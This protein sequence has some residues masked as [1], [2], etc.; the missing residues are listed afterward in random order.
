MRSSSAGQLPLAPTT[1][2]RSAGPASP[3]V[4]LSVAAPF[5]PGTDAASTPAAGTAGYPAPASAPYQ[6]VHDTSPPPGAAAPGAAAHG[7]HLAPTPPSTTTT[8]RAPH[9]TT[10]TARAPHTTTT[11][12]ARAGV[13]LAPTPHVTT[14]TFTTTPAPPG[15][16]RDWGA[17]PSTSG[18]TTV[19]NTVP[20]SLDTFD[21]ITV[22]RFLCH[23]SQW[24]KELLDRG[25]YAPPLSGLLTP[26]FLGYSTK[27]LHSTLG[28]LWPAYHDLADASSG[29][30][31]SAMRTALWQY[32][33]DDCHT[34]HEDPDT[35]WATLS[36]TVLWPRQPSS[37]KGALFDFQMAFEELLQS[38][39]TVAHA[40]TSTLK[41]QKRTVNALV[42]KLSP[43]SWRHAVHQT[44]EKSDKYTI[45]SFFALL[46]SASTEI[47]FHAFASTA[48]V[49][50]E[51]PPTPPT[52]TPHP[53]TSATPEPPFSPY[54]T[55]TPSRPCRFCSGRHMDNACPTRYN[56]N[57]STSAAPGT[58]APTAT[59]TSTSTSATT[60]APPP[61][62][63]RF[64][65]AAHWHSDCP[66]NPAGRTPSTSTSRH[67]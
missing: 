17:L 57:F 21:H 47:Q 7:V 51:P 58:T 33:N 5:A 12:T 4:D 9:S 40:Y 2:A 53:A 63:C 66:S 29:P 38:H 43:A 39:P 42:D 26:R 61:A 10:T 14:T 44:L 16:P 23:E 46:T 24:R 6:A 35:P 50:P 52:P 41:R 55:T 20:P 48:S 27:F 3:H 19:D 59:R 34:A 28:Q 1:R 54:P 30:W 65:G 18:L 56:G 37:F 32:V 62:P 49:S 60:R 67:Y 22:R 15:A 45:D 8:A 64:C 13:H 11:T 25:R 31:E 36:T